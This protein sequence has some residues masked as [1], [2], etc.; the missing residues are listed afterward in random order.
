MKNSFWNEK[1]VFVTGCTGLLG[2]WMVKYLLEKKAQ[3]VGLVRD[4][5]PY[6]NLKYMGLFDKI[7]IVRG[8]L[9][10]YFLLR[11]IINEYEIEVVYHLGAQAI[12][13]V[14]NNDPLSTFESN[15]KGTWNIL[16]ACRQF[17]KVKQIVVAS[18]DKAY[19]EKEKLPYKEEDALKGSHP[20]DV[21]KSCADLIAQS[22]FRTYGLPVCVSRCANLY[23]GGDLNFSRIIPGT[24]RSV[25]LNEPP[26]IRSDGRYIRDYFYV[27]DAVLALINLV[28]KMHSDKIHGEAFNFN[29]ARHVNVLELVNKILK[30]MDSKLRP[31]ILNEAKNE[32]KDQYLSSNKACK[33]LNWESKY[34]LDFGLKN[35]I[36]WYKDYFNNGQK[37]L[38]GR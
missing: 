15:I 23:G 38:C 21:S 1:K 35:T 18:S 10:D 25:I 11:R 28:E 33:L 16:E 6:S 7:T 8:G 2:S 9:E 19:G 5:L 4:A 17:A 26:I 37:K 34:S 30:L 27:E 24:I 14:A 36:S 32:I 29:S 3:V 20:Y 31:K 12:V 13:G 22:Y